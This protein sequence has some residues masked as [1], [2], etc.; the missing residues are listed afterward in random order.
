[1]ALEFYKAISDDGGVIG[2]QISSGVTGALLPEITKNDRLN[3]VVIHRKFYIKNLSTLIALHTSLDELGE[4]NACLF[5]SAGDT[6]VVG[7][8]TGTE[9]KYG[10]SEITYVEDTTGHTETENGVGGLSDI[11]KVRVKKNSDFTFFRV[12]EK[13]GIGGSTGEIGTL[14]T[15]TDLGSEI[16]LE[17][18]S[19]LTYKH[20]IGLNAHSYIQSSVDTAVSI[21]FWLQVKVDA[22]ASTS[23]TFNALSLALV[24]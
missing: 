2:E 9:D 12:G 11:K 15:V 13:V 6:E 23:S 24:Y 1:M 19:E 3:G 20:A 22:N 18:S 5:L 16:E 14:S 21:P 8:L 17:F 10:A 7:D 4:F